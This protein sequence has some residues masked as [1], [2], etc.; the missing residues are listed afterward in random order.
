MIHSTMKMQFNSL[1]QPMLHI[2]INILNFKLVL[3]G[4]FSLRILLIQILIVQVLELL[5]IL[6]IMQLMRVR[7]HRMVGKDILKLV[8]YFLYRFDYYWKRNQE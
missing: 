3:Q 7:L 4:S 2:L 8:I 1:L 6:V 5:T